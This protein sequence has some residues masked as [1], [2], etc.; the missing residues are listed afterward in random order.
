MS[1][2][3]RWMDVWIRAVVVAAFRRAVAVWIGTGIVAAGVFGPTAMHPRDLTDLALHEPVVGGILALTWMLVFLPAARV[4][5]RG[6]TA[7]YLRSLPGP[8]IA[9]L[10]LGAAALIALQLPWLALWT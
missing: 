6:E 10:A 4:L 7:A 1:A 8:T 2:R 9:P 5:V 3:A